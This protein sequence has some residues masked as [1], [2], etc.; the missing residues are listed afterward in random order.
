VVIVNYCQWSQTAALV[1][2]ILTDPEAPPDAIEVVVVDNHSPGDPI[3][4]RFRRMNGVSLRRWKRNRG[5]AAA[6]NEGCRL[7]QGQWF[8]VLNPDVVLGKD[9]LGRTLRLIDRLP[10]IRPRAGILG[11]RLLDQT[12]SWQRSTGHDP[13]LLGTLARLVLPRARRKY[14]SPPNDRATTVPWVTGCCVLIRRECMRQLGGFDEQFFLYYEDVDFCRRARRLGWSVWYE[15]A[16]HAVHRHPLHSRSVPAHLRVLTRHALLVYARKHWPNWQFRWLGRLVAAEAW[17]R[18]RWACHNGRK[19]EAIP[20]RHLSRL[21]RDP[22]RVGT[23]AVRRRL[24]RL[25]RLAGARLV[26]RPRPSFIPAD[27][28]AGYRRSLRALQLT[29]ANRP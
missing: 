7:S 29:V 13:N 22:E 9:F 4:P 15:P 5:F 2:Q 28:P 17:L 8:L 3:V 25:V 16:L 12:G 14:N 10:A 19:R 26:G 27:V 11:F 23:R 1:R 6:V 21:A 24:E 18:G 20:Y